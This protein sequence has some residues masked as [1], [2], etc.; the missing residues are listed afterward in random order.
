MSKKSPR[1]SIIVTTY[2]RQTL[3]ERC[4]ASLLVQE[5]PRDEYEIIVVDDGS[6]DTTAGLLTVL[7]REGQVRY[8][9]QEN[10]GWSVAR[11]TGL[12]RS[13]G[14]I[15]VFTDDD[16]RVPIDWLARYNTAYQ[17]HPEFAGIAGSMACDGG[18]NL[19]GKIRH[20]VHLET[21][22]LLNAPLKM[23]HQD[24]GEVL[25]C[26]GA[27][28]SFRREVLIGS[29][30][31]MTLLYFDDYDLNLQLHERGVR[32]YYDPAI[33]VTHCYILSARDRI[34]ADY[35]FGLSAVVFAR[36]H[37]KQSYPRPARGSL[38]RLRE[39]YRDEPL[40]TKLSYVA[41][42]AMCRLARQWGYLRGA[43]QLHRARR[44]GQ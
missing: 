44:R 27:N 18:A 41:V 7:A 9:H 39:E 37:S 16:C 23:T 38:T 4:L 15:V 36:K 25:F 12:A 10:C 32:I 21:F 6:G 11:N 8:I 30:F 26:Y 35:R 42:Q 29:S 2:N 19:A 13:Q 24:A 31:D 5:F 14:E 43:W 20:Q 17:E 40:S 33:Q 28:R 3:L 22:D 1:F 34:L